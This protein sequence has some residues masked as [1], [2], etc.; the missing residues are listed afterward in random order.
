MALILAHLYNILHVHVY[1]QL[2]AIQKAFIV[3][4]EG[5][6]G[7]QLFGRS[8]NTAAAAF[9][10]TATH[11]FRMV[12]LEACGV[13][14]ENW[15]TGG[16]RKRTWLKIVSS[17]V[18]RYAMQPSMHWNFFSVRADGNRVH[19]QEI[20]WFCDGGDG[21]VGQLTEWTEPPNGKI[22]IFFIN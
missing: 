10:R 14:P 12:M 9:S 6:K 8:A 11:V 15:P 3:G 7:K 1:L 5:T 13:N 16:E 2:N 4:V 20:R 22:L 17:R 21:G 19:P 18:L